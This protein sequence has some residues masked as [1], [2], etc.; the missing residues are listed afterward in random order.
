MRRSR[1][2]TRVISAGHRVCRGTLIVH[3][4]PDAG[5]DRPAMI[6]LVVGRSVGNSVVRH[7]VS[8]RLRAQLR[9]RLRA[10]PAGSR[11]VVRA[12]PEA[13]AADSRRLGA[14]LDAALRRAV[15][16]GISVGSG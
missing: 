9:A 12:L 6:G 3:Y 7:R 2:F 11:T 1:D 5:A 8:R 16:A 4:H 10:L 14:D 15:T 13:A